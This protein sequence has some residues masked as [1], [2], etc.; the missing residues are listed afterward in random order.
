MRV[1]TAL[2]SNTCIILH[3][4]YCYCRHDGC[5]LQENGGINMDL[6]PG[7]QDCFYRRFG[8]H[9]MMDDEVLL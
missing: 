1:P 6:W 5:N 9:Q 8:V 4:R 2:T 7:E 3:F